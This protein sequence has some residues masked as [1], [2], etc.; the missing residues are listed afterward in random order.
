MYTEANTEMKYQA[1][2]KPLVWTE[3]VA[4]NIELKLVEQ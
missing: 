3:K 1:E 4:E 2:V